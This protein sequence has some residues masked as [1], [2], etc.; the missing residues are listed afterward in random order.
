MTSV[1]VQ[2]LKVCDL[3]NASADKNIYMRRSN[4]NKEVFN[5]A[6]W[7]LIN[8]LTTSFMKLQKIDWNDSLAV[9]STRRLTLRH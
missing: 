8:I 1:V 3:I 6:K 2:C 4:H 9:R 7:L 5:I